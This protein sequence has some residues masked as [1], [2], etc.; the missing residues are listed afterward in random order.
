MDVTLRIVFF[1]LSFSS[2]PITAVSTFIRID[3]VRLPSFT[4]DLF[5][6]SRTEFHSR[7]I[8]W[9]GQADF[10]R[11]SF[12]FVTAVYTIRPHSRECEEIRTSKRMMKMMKR[13]VK[14]NGEKS[15]SNRTFER[16]KWQRNAMQTWNISPP[17]HGSA[18]I[19][20]LSFIMFLH[21]SP[22]PHQREKRFIFLRDFSISIPLDSVAPQPHQ[23][24]S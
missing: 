7:T 22:S 13:Q 8:E 4:V 12:A 21:P 14:W 17:F 19:L 18:R 6:N 24:H 10:P 1:F 15:Q 16:I 11:K 9:F 20:I 23:H 2:C 5:G 3:V